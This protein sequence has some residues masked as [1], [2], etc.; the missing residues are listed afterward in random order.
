[1]NTFV[2]RAFNALFFTIFFFQ[3]R[4]KLFFHLS[5]QYTNIPGS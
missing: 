1:M 3:E 2:L 4:D 5:N